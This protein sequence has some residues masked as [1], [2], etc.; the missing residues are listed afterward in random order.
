MIY[1]ATCFDPIGS[2]SVRYPRHVKEVHTPH[3]ED[4]SRFLQNMLQ[5]SLYAFSL[6]L[7]FVAITIKIKI[8][9]F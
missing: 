4:R 2:S 1:S 3:M 6:G 9:F 5:R 7:K 8:K